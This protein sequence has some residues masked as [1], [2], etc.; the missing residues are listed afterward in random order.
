VLAPKASGWGA[1]AFHRRKTNAIRQAKAAGK[2]VRC[3][4]RELG[5]GVGTVLRVMSG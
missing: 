1:L 2:G 5:V 4:A 3:I